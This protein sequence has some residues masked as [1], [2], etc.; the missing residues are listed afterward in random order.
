MEMNHGMVTTIPLSLSIPEI[1]IYLFFSLKH[2][3][4]GIDPYR[5]RPFTL[6][7]GIIDFVNVFLSAL[8]CYV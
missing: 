5:Y 7:S 2:E 1:K 8:I 3:L 4:P 6:P